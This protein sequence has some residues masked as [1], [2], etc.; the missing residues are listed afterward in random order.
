VTAVTNRHAGS[1]MIIAVREFSFGPL[2]S[3][4]A[5]ALSWSSRNLPKRQNWQTIQGPKQEIR[6]YL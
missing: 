6:K 3:A 5:D 1:N 4:G 2:L